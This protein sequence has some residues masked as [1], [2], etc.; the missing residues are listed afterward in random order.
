MG[1]NKKKAKKQSKKLD[2]KTVVSIIGSMASGKSTQMRMLVST[3]CKG[4]EP[5]EIIVGNTVHYNLY[6]KARIIVLGKVAKNATGIGLDGCYSKL[7][8][9]GVTSTLA[10]ALEDKN[11]D[12]ILIDCALQTM[13]WHR[14][15]FKTGLRKKYKHITAYLFLD[16]FHNLKRLA[17]RK[18]KAHKQKTGESLEWY[19][20]YHKDTVY[21]NVLAKNRENRNI[22]AKLEGTYDPSKLEP[23]LV[24]DKAIQIDALLSP[25]K[26]HKTILKL[27]K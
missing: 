10:A 11:S 26:I 25:K 18:S 1:K 2:K 13:S 7:K 4:E 17:E 24:S 8:V 3:L 6:K 27:I 22:F 14:S 19:E 20:I 21:K 23:E 16:Y 12:L 15:F 5:Q 9:A